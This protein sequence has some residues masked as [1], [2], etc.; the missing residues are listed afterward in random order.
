MDS[1]R[2]P[3]SEAR[4]I[5]YAIPIGIVAWVIIGVAVYWVTRS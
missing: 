4:G 3:L 2:D 5:V 1:M